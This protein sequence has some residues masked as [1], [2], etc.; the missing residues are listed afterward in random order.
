MK[1]GI[2]SDHA[3]YELKA[4]L[5]PL[6]EQAGYEL[7]D[8][9]CFSTDR[10]DYPEYTLKVVWNMV[11]GNA[12]RGLLCC[13]NGFAAAMLANRIPG[14]RAAVCHDAFSARTTVEMGGANLLVFGQRV[15]G[16]ELAWDL[17]QIWLTAEF[18]GISVPRYQKRLEEVEE[19]SSR[20]AKEKWREE[21]EGFI[22]SFD[23]SA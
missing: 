16:F 1:I 11:S 6:L 20:F 17:A 22:Q 13:G 18:R 3:G 19:L 21:L 14:I 23:Q 12:E 10:V 7:L 15:V 8:T 5:I 9:G 4:Y 2:G